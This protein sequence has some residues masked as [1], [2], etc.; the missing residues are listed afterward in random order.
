MKISRGNNFKNKIAIILC[1]FLSI[2]HKTE[3][4]T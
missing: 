1:I 2:L 4:Q 3:A